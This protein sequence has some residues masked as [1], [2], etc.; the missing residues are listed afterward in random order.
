MSG[1]VSCQGAIAPSL[2]SR[3]ISAFAK[4]MTQPIFEKLHPAGAASQ[5]LGKALC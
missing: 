4:A 3:P 5:K 2:A 1:F